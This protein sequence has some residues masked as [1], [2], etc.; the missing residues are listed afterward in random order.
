MEVVADVKKTTPWHC[1]RGCWESN[2]APGGV[3]VLTGCRSLS[4]H[5]EPEADFQR[6]HL[7]QKT[8]PCSGHGKRTV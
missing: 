2:N 5:G 4:V 1:R 8:K 7:D 3:V 6:H